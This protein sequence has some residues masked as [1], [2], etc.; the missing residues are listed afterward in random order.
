MLSPGGPGEPT[1]GDDSASL[2]QALMEL[3]QVSHAL[4]TLLTPDHDQRPR[5][6]VPIERPDVCARQPGHV[7]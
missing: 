5:Y 1:T 4:A 3:T 7:L 6:L 2:M